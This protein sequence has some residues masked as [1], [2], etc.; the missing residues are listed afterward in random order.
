M[1][2]QM[3]VP[4]NNSAHALLAVRKY[5]PAGRGSIANNSRK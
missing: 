2:R 5:R 3:A 1:V 4:C